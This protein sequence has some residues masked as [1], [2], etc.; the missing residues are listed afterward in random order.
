MLI[1]WR[2]FDFVGGT[3][4]KSHLLPLLPEPPRMVQYLI[5]NA[6]VLVLPIEVIS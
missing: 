1:P 4:R 3:K 2:V 5:L 6:T